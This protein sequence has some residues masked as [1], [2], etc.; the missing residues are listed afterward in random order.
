M[1]GPFPFLGRMRPTKP[2]DLRTTSAKV[3]RVCAKVKLAMAASGPGVI[4]HI[5][6]VETAAEVAN[7][8]GLDVVFIGPGD[9]ATSMGLR[10]RSDHPD[11]QTIQVTIT[12]TTK[13]LAMPYG[14]PRCNVL[15]LL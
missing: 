3:D 6:A 15:N 10:G 2:D 8:P 13:R 4:E 7:T 11:V 5:D 14:M 12:A 9:L 1:S